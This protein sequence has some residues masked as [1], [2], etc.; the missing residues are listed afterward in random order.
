MW[1]LFRNFATAMRVKP[2]ALVAPEG[3]L[4]RDIAEVDNLA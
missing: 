3:A 1:K 2:L 4:G